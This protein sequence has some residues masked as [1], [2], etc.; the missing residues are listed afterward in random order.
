VISRRHLIG[1]G[2]AASVLG[3]VGRVASANHTLPPPDARFA[4]LLAT[5]VIVDTRFDEAV[6]I[7]LGAAAPGAR[8][9]ALPRDVLELWHDR[10]A[11][12]P[13]RPPQTFAGVTTEHGLFT[14]RTLAADHRQRVLYTTVH[15]SRHGGEPLVSWLIG[16]APSRG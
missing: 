14:L 5:Q 3:L 10:L 12:T 6:E 7:A 16:P 13:A 8:V 1:S 11:P 15:A 9:I 2:M 4:P